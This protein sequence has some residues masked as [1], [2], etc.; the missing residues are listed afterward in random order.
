[1]KTFLITLLFITTISFTSKA[2][3]DNKLRFQLGGFASAIGYNNFEET[4][5]A[6]YGVTG[7]LR[8]KIKDLPGKARLEFCTLP[9]IGLIGLGVGEVYTSTY[10]PVTLEYALG[11]NGTKESPRMG[12]IMGGGLGAGTS[13]FLGASDLFFYAGPEVNIAVRARFFGVQ[14]YYRLSYLLNVASG[15]NGKSIFG[16]AFTRDFKFKR[17]GRAYNPR[18]VRFG[19]GGEWQ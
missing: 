12:F 1:M 7:H 10:L 5:V 2:Q 11:N 19:N 14:R 18:K 13:S 8:F 9:S 15:A 17:S 3:Y 4:F 6:G 16:I